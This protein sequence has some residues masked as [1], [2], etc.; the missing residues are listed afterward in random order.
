MARCYNFSLTICKMKQQLLLTVLFFFPVSTS[1][2]SSSLILTFDGEVHGPALLPCI[3]DD[4]TGV[5][6]SMGPVHIVKF[7]QGL[8]GG[9]QGE[10]AG[11]TRFHLL[12]PSEPFQ[13]EWS[14]A[15]HHGRETHIGA[16][17]SL[18]GLRRHHKRWRFWV[19]AAEDS[20]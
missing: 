10:T 6:S 15:L 8:V 11:P 3:V 20:C 9:R 4:L 19:L 18:L 14:A 5:L 13:L 7:Q 12:G 1:N 17:Q 2:F 16:W